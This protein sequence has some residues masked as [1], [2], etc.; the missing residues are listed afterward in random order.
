MDQHTLDCAL[1]SADVYQSDIGDNLSGAGWRR[2]TDIADS[3]KPQ[4]AFYAALYCQFKNDKPEQAVLA[5]R[6]TIFDEDNLIVDVLAWYSDVLGIGKH[7][8]DPPGFFRLAQ[9]FTQSVYA[10]LKQHYPAILDRQTIS[11]T[12]HSLG[13]ALAQLIS[14]T[15][16]HPQKTIVFN[17]PGCGN[18]PAVNINQSFEITNVNA[19]YGVINKIGDVLGDVI[20]I[21]VKAREAEARSMFESEN[22]IAMKTSE[23][24]FSAAAL[25]KNKFEAL[26]INILASIERARAFLHTIPT[27]K[28]FPETARVLSK[29]KHKADH[30]AWYDLRS[31]LKQTETDLG[32]IFAT[33]KAVISAQH[34]ISHVIEALDVNA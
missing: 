21:D 8:Q 17:S 3:P 12:G 2:V 7:D 10:Y 34:D 5:F 25:A 13:G 30:L 6:G 29:D 18:L 24:L 32:A 33:Y 11:Y 4:D 26:G 28:H 19:R 22:H 27:I 31:K 20:L 9:V 23:A 16:D 15:T 1:L 14:L